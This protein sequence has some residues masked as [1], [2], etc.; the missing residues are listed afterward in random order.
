M[1]ARRLAARP[2]PP[3]RKLPS[4]SGPRCASVA[5]IEARRS[6][7]TA[8]RVEAIPQIPHTPPSLPPDGLAD[9]AKRSEDDRP[10][11]QRHGAVCDP[12]EVVRQLF[13]HRRL[14]AAAHLREAGEAG[15]NDEA[16]PVRGQLVR[17]L[18]EEPRTDRPR[19]DEGHVAAEH[20]PEL[21][22]LVELRRLQP[23]AE[24]RVLRLGPADELGAE[25]GAEPGLGVRPE[26]PELD[27]REEV[28]VPTD[29]L[30]AIED[31]PA[32]AREDEERD[33]GGER[34]QEQPEGG[35]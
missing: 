2:T 19:A 9:D 23:P 21:R 30:A 32:V 12:L 11:V 27:D 35:R 4:E 7:S 6:R 14:V 29:T 33:R 22:N 25:V 10:Q 17:Q 3:S 15:P 26:R 20:V 13:G 24:R 18:G 28:P 34:Q 8:P 5:D 16:L 31:R 1:I